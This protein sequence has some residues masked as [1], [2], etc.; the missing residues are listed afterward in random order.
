MQTSTSSL[1]RS[2]SRGLTESLTSARRRHGVFEKALLQ[3]KRLFGCDRCRRHRRRVGG[4]YEYALRVV[5]AKIFDEMKVLLAKEEAGVLQ[6][7][8]YATRRNTDDRT[9]GK[10]EGV[11]LWV[12]KDT[13]T[14]E[15]RLEEGEAIKSF[16]L[17][18]TIPS[19]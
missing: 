18:I 15:P 3:F 1:S 19:L 10:R 5:G 7:M 11:C 14:C 16:Q 6:A 4:K 13:P 8:E 12:W 9:A 2:C 17:S